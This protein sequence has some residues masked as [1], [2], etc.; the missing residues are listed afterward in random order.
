MADDVLTEE[1][2]IPRVKAAERQLDAAIQLWLADGDALAVHTLAMASYS[3][4]MDLTAAK[5]KE[6][7]HRADELII[8]TMGYAAFRH[9]ANQL[10]HGDRDPESP[11]KIPDQELNESIMGGALT[12]FRVITGGVSEVMGA[13][14]LM[15]LSAHPEAFQ[16][17]D[18]PDPDIE[19][20]AQEGARILRAEIS[21]RHSTVEAN[22]CL[23][24]GGHIPANIGVRR[25]YHDE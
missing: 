7:H 16:V 3:V 10:K 9:V 12:F 4:L 23:I 19:A 8:K 11:V 17:A 2:G 13:F 20:G 21:L 5:D 22:L 24:M 18:D 1:T 25:K 6:F 14:H 15:M